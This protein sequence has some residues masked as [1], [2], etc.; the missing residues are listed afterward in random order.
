MTIRR[1][2]TALT[3]VVALTLVATACGDDPADGV[4]SGTSESTLPS[5]D[6][7]P[8]GSGSLTLAGTDYPFDADVCALTPVNHIARD[9]EIYVHGTGEHQGD[10]YEVEVTR[11]TS[12]SGN[13][14]ES[15][16][17]AFGDG[18]LAGGTNTIATAEDAV[19]EVSS[20]LLVGEMEFIGTD[21]ITIGTGAVSVTCS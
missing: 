21:D 2:A 4:G 9:Y 12:A 8:T 1:L 20:S 15:I 13:S 7:A 5:S 11:S 14:I 16:S 6:G 19:L 18:E 17:I 3:S 10:A